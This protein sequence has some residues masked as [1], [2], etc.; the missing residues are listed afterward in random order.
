[1]RLAQSRMHVEASCEG[2]FELGG[3]SGARPD[4]A[5]VGT[6]GMIPLGARWG[7]RRGV[8][9]GRLARVD[10]SYHRDRARPTYQHL[11]RVGEVREALRRNADHVAMH[12]IPALSN[13]GGRFAPLLVLSSTYASMSARATPPWVSEMPH[14]DTTHVL[15][16]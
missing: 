11:L 12:I 10:L 8:D 4:R 2:G 16:T 6:W 15:Q 5:G 14:R 3:H 9:L 1:M 7:S 13:G